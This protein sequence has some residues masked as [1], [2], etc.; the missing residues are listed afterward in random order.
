MYAKIIGD[1]MFNYD[2]VIQKHLN[3]LSKY[4]KP[5]E[6]D[7]HMRN[8][9]NQYKVY[10]VLTFVLMASLFLPSKEQISGFD[11]FLPSVCFIMAIHRWSELR[12]LILYKSLRDDGV[13]VQEKQ[14]S[15]DDWTS[16]ILV[17]T[18]G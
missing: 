3:V 4:D 18:F 1:T 10:I 12:S 5:E 6:F 17:G 7:A 14:A 2:K 8:L 16:E 13:S 9:Y 11:T 15:I